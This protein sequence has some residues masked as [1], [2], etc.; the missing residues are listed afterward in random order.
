MKVNNDIQVAKSNCQSIFYFHFI[1]SAAFEELGYSLLWKNK[2]I[3]FLKIR[4]NK[5]IIFRD[6]SSEF[7]L[8]NFHQRKSSKDTFHMLKIIFVMARIL[9]FIMYAKLP[10]CKIR[11]FLSN[12]KLECLISKATD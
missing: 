9:R 4:T 5:F 11:Y 2:N 3:L 7:L 12:L 8:S 1:L 6:F 10:H